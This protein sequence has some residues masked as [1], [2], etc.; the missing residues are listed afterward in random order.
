VCRNEPSPTAGKPRL[1]TLFAHSGHS[2]DLAA[3]EAL[4]IVEDQRDRLRR[5]PH[6]LR[7]D[8]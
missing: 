8:D 2:R 1:H 7:S 3:T 6:Q 4:L 5:R